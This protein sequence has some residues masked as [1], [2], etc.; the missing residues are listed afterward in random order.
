MKNVIILGQLR[1][2]LT[3]VGGAL[4]A[5]GIVDHG[6]V[7]EGIGAVMTATGFALSV[8]AKL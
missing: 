4:V 2:I 6:L 7:M 3:A 8:R 5:F 1:H